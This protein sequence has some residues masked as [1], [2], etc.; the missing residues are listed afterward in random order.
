MSAEPIWLEGP[1]D[2]N[3]VPGPMAVVA[4]EEALRKSNDLRLKEMIALY[5][6]AP[7]PST[8]NNA[9]MNLLLDTVWGKIG[10]P[11]RATIELELQKHFTLIIEKA[12]SHLRQQTLLGG[13]PMH[14]Q[15]PRP[16]GGIILP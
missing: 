16:N 2:F 3:D 6:Q 9:R 1:D 12:E 13:G 15:A 5:G 10:T 7:D 8:W 14:P 11:E 4:E